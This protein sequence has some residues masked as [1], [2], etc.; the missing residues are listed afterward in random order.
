M[1]YRNT[2][3][4][5]PPIK[6]VNDGVPLLG[7]H[8]DKIFGISL[9]IPREGGGEE[10]KIIYLHVEYGANCVWAH[11]TCKPQEAPYTWST[12]G[13]MALPPHPSTQ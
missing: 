7:L 2:D 3:L 5:V 10:Q 11:S 12:N 9:A 1:R 8:D 6:P 4:Y 13:N